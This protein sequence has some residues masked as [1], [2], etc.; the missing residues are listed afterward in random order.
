MQ[1]LLRNIIIIISLFLAVTLIL[2]FFQR[3]EETSLE[4]PQQKNMKLTS[5]AFNNNQYIPSKY[6]CNGEDLNPPLGIKDVPEGTKSLVLIVE[7]P[8]APMGTWTHWLIWNIDPLTSLIEENT[9]PQGAIEGL[10]DFE[11]RSYGGPCPP[12]GTHHYHFKLY[13]LDKMLDLDSSSKK[14]DIINAM[15]GS[16]LDW[17]ELIGI[18]Q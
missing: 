13:A 14:E 11:K 17:S 4:L 18:Y 1:K 6:T 10:N 8:D 9:V 5:P 12:S 16:I 3:S 15:Q 7:D 2:H